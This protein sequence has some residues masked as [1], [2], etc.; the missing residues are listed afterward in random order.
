MSTIQTKTKRTPAERLAALDTER[1]RLQR[2]MAAQD[3]PERAQALGDVIAAIGQWSF[4][5]VELADAWPRKRAFA[6]RPRKAKAAQ[7]P[8]G[9]GNGQ[10]GATN[11][12]AGT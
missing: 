12:A 11:A 7:T 3:S 2:Q 4:T 8:S 6:P 9:Q 10:A 5:R 1:E